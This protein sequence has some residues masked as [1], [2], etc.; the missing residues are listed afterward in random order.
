MAPGT[1]SFVVGQNLRSATYRLDLELFN[2][3]PSTSGDGIPDWWKALYG[4]SNP[5]GVTS[6]DGLSN[7][8]KFQDGGTP[9]MDNRFPTLLNHGML[10]LCRRPHGSP[11]GRG[12]FRQFCHQ[13]LF[14]ASNSLP[15]NGTF[16]LRNY[17]NDVTLA[18][19]SK[20]TLDDVNR[21][22]LIFAH[23]GPSA[24]ASA[25]SFNLNLCDETPSHATNYTV[26]LDVYRPSYPSA[27]VQAAQAAA[28]RCLVSAIFQDWHSA[29]SRC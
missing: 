10:G 22:R 26:W 8:Q 14:H 25:T 2:P 21:G 6:A 11:A 7:L 23:A 18:I 20:F 16:Y 3:L 24:P 29:S 15:A 28:A 1:S 12:G 19:G 27:V 17:S 5:N 13:H 4:V 9:N